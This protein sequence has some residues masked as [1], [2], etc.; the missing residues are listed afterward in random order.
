MIKYLNGCFD[1]YSCR[2]TDYHVY[3]E[4]EQVAAD[5]PIVLMQNAAYYRQI[6]LQQNVCYAASTDGSQQ[7]WSAVMCSLDALTII[8]I[9]FQE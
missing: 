8:C 3:S 4:V 2:S 1:N 7:Q 5:P 6:Q 9:M